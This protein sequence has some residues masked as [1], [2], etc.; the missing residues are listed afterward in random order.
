[1]FEII[2]CLRGLF[3]ITIYDKVIRNCD[4][5]CNCKR[6]RA[7]RELVSLR[8]AAKQ[9]N[10]VKSHDMWSCFMLIT[11]V[12]IFPLTG[13]DNTQHIRPFHSVKWADLKSLVLFLVFFSMECLIQWMLILCSSVENQQILFLCCIVSFDTH[14]LFHICMC[15][16]RNHIFILLN[17]WWILHALIWFPLTIVSQRKRLQ[18]MR[19]LRFTTPKSMDSQWNVHGEKRAAIQIMRHQ[20]QVKLWA[21]L[22]F[23]LAPHMDNK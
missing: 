23:H 16:Y 19:S 2:L 7:K 14:Y 17:N 6:A 5:H 4:C 9:F 10:R 3:I 12:D 20:L 18:H 15:C 1:M 13:P 22:A 8:R 11:F 21:R